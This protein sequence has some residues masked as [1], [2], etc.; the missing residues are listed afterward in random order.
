MRCADLVDPGF[1][2]LQPGH[3]ARLHEAVGDLA[4]RNKVVV[5]SAAAVGMAVSVW[6]PS[7][8]WGGAVE[9]AAPAVCDSS[10]SVCDHFAQARVRPYHGFVGHVHAADRDPQTKAWAKPAQ[11][12]PTL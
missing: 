1:P 3:H 7:I 10:P 2:G 12:W 11:F 5:N 9:S 4:L 6:L 8:A